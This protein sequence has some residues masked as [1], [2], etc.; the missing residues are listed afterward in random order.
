M[1][2]AGSRRDRSHPGWTGRG[3]QAARRPG[4]AVRPDEPERLARLAGP[5][6]RAGGM[7][8]ESVQVTPA[9]RRR[10]VKVVVDADG[11]AGLDDMAEISRALSTELDASGAMGDAP[12]TLEV[13]SPGV[14]RPLTEPRH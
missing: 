8:L 1:M 7:E 3:A 14:D 12:Y 6:V 11:G 5:V 9:G 10:V 4:S 13:S 2:R